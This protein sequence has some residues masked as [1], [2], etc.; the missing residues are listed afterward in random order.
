[1]GECVWQV[2]SSVLQCGQHAE[3][4]TYIRIDVY[5]STCFYLH[6]YPFT[7]AYLL[8]PTNEVN[9]HHIPT[10]PNWLTIQ[11]GPKEFFTCQE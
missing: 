6:I 11:I 7:Y 3:E 9:V 1:M 8:T 2:H 10:N 4:A 5:L